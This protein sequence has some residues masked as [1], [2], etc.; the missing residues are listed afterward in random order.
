MDTDRPSRMMTPLHNP[1]LCSALHCE[2]GNW[3]NTR[4]ALNKA[5]RGAE[6]SE[7]T[8]VLIMNVIL[9]DWM[10]IYLVR[11]KECVCF[12]HA[13]IWLFITRDLY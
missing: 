9:R 11:S 4:T 2:A 7:H 10:D 6:T 1:D 8:L 3:E 5:S 12:L 13:R